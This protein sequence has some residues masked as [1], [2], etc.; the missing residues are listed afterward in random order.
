MSVV[1]ETGRTESRRASPSISGKLFV[2]LVTL[3]MRV[4]SDDFRDFIRP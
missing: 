1:V 2:Q 3:G 4:A